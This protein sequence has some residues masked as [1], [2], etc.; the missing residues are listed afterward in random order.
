ME[1]GRSKIGHGCFF[2]G[3]GQGPSHPESTSSTSLVRLSPVHFHP[4]W[5]RR[6][7]MCRLVPCPRRTR[8]WYKRDCFEDWVNHYFRLK[9]LNSMMAYLSGSIS[10]IRF[11]PSNIHRSRRTCPSVT[12]WTTMSFVAPWQQLFGTCKNDQ[13]ENSVFIHVFIAH[14]HIYISIYTL[15]SIIYIYIVSDVLQCLYLYIYIYIDIQSEK[16]FLQKQHVHTT[17]RNL[18]SKSAIF[19][20]TKVVPLQWNAIFL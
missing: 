11:Y 2:L 5:M 16:F 10:S 3:A 1:C 7:R 13:R 8:P 6:N 15:F 18:F 20:Q 14:T 19:H 17:C 4:G 9:L 12:F